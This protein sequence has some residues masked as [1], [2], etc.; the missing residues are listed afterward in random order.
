M[1]TLKAFASI[2][3]WI[4]KGDVETKT[5]D[6]DGNIL[7]SGNIAYLD[8]TKVGEAAQV[9]AGLDA[10]VTIAKGLQFDTNW[11]FNSKM[12]GLVDLASSEF[13][14]ENNRGSI[15]LPSYNTV[16]TG[17]SY[18]VSFASKKSLQFRL[19]VNN[20][21]NEFYIQGVSTNNYIETG[22]ATWKGINTNNKVDLGYGTT[23][24]FST[25][26]NF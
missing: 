22:D 2:G 23:W 20:V 6:L 24:N 15:E 10:V 14:T 3:D 1:I 5:L 4:Y 19:N 11:N 18:K 8:G 12:Y 7:S 25:Q 26:F 16:D 9:T 13:E 21:F 17:L